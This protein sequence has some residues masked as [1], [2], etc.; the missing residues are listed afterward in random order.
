ML[1]V[2]LALTIS[3]ST[4]WISRTAVRGLNVYSILTGS[5]GT[6]CVSSNC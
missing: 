1:S 6:R 4:S 5:G 2:P 3:T